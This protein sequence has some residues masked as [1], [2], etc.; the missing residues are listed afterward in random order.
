MDRGGVVVADSGVGCGLDP[1]GVVSC[2]LDH[3][4]VAAVAPLGVEVALG[5]EAG[6]DSGEQACLLVRGKKPGR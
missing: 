5:G 3:P 6:G 1:V 2:S 4:R